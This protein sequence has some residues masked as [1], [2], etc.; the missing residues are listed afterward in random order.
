MKFKY[1]EN[2]FLIILFRYHFGKASQKGL[3][4]HDLIN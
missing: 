4:Q 2:H 1:T 3:F